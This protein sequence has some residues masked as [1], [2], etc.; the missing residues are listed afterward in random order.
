MEA[1]RR[2]AAESDVNMIVT[3]EKDAPKLHHVEQYPVLSLTIDLKLV[4]ST[5][6]KFAEFVLNS[7][8]I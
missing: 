2:R 4:D 1:I 7:M 8:E 5:A 6:E 3:T